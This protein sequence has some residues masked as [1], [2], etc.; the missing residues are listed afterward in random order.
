MKIDFRVRP[1]FKSFLDTY[2]Y[3]PR[4]PNP[5]PVTMSGLRMG[6][7]P[8]ESFSGKSMS[9]FMSEMDEA[10]IDMAVVMGRKAPPS[11]GSIANEDIAELIATYP[12]RFMGFGGLGGTDTKAI[13][14][15]VDRIIALGLVGAAMDNGYW[16]MYDDDERLRQVYEKL[17]DA[18]LI[19]ALTSSMFIGDDMTYCMPVHIQRVAKRFPQLTIVVPHGGWPWTTQM[20]AVAFQC[21]NVYLVP[22]FYMHLPGIPGADQYLLAANSFL[23]HRLLYA[24]SYPIRPLGQS[25]SQ[26]EGLAF[27]SDEIR[28]RCLGS[29]AARLLKLDK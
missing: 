16:G 4:D 2:L 6:L 10:G 20:C 17:S 29:N 24:S 11:L 1:P 9:A 7:E 3:K 15:E 27:A 14:A 19:L 21:P 8:Y 26:F 23:S 13:L 22:D 12:G 5:D 25:V 18:G 28:Q